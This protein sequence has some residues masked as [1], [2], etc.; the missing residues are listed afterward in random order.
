MMR[1]GSARCWSGGGTYGQWRTKAGGFNTLYAFDPR[2][3][4]ITRL[5]DCPTVLCRAALAHDTKRDLFVTVAS[6]KGGQ[7][8]QPSGMY[9]YDPQQDA[10]HRITPTNPMPDLP[11]TF[12]MP[13]CYDSTHGFIGLAGATFQAFRYAP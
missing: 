5:A 11:S 8:E 1:P 9:A 4:A 2:T 10:W 3:E 12:W 6:L 7:V 13:L